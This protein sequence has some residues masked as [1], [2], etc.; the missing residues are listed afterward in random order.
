MLS[1]DTSVRTALLTMYI[2]GLVF[3]IVMFFVLNHLNGKFWTR[4]SA[5]ISIIA[6]IMVTIIT[7]LINVA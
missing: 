4:A 2:I 5:G 3:L 6:I 7:F 1:Q